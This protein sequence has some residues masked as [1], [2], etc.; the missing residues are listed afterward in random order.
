MLVGK[1]A[2]GPSFEA[3]LEEQTRAMRDDEL[4]KEITA[5]MELVRLLL[6]VRWSERRSIPLVP[7]TVL[8]AVLSNVAEV[9]GSPGFKNGF[10]AASVQ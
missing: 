8:H 2:G 4:C 6:L 3:W 10:N 5:G 1:N 7:G 9:A